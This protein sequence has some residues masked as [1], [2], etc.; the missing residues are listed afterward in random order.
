MISRVS[1]AGS[2]EALVSTLRKLVSLEAL[3]DAA[4]V[5]PLEEG[6]I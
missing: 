3:E 1:F 5:A 4:E 6:T 2:G